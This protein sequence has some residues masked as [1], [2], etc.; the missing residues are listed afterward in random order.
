M[1]LWG[2]DSMLEPLVVVRGTAG[3]CASVPV[4]FLLPLLLCMVWI[5]S[6]LSFVTYLHAATEK[7]THSL[8]L[9]TCNTAFTKL[10]LR[11]F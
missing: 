10:T 5:S 2:T 8:H 9:L 7:H 6:Y 1:T 11:V 4:Y 3:A